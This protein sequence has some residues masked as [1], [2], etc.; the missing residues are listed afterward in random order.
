MCLSTLSI[1]QYSLSSP[2]NCSITRRK[3]TKTL[4]TP[5]WCVLGLTRSPAVW[6][7]PAQP[8][9]PPLAWAGHHHP[10][11]GV[12]CHTGSQQFLDLIFDCV[13][14][15]MYRNIIRFSPHPLNQ[16]GTI[17]PWPAHDDWPQLSLLAAAP[18]VSTV[19]SWP[20]GS[21]VTTA[22]AGWLFSER[23]RI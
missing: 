3:N 18:A 12:R 17:H 9:Q 1:I 21:D 11:Q 10:L 19:S 5:C 8:G 16:P 6:P 23:E 2:S 4:C 20:G 15:I 7:G 13:Y 14:K 22:G